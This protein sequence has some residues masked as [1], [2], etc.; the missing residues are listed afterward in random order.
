MQKNENKNPHKA[1]GQ[2]KRET[3]TIYTHE[4]V[5]RAEWRHLGN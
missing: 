4:R 3:V 1:A 5:I 2:K